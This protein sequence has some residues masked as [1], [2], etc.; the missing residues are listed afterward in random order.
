M[1]KK[2]SEMFF[3]SWVFHA[4]F[5]HKTKDEGAGEEFSPEISA[6]V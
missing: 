5:S 3:P 2:D 6:S 1:V 4:G